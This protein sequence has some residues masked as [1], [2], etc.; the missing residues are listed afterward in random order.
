MNG[1]SDVRLS[2]RAGELSERGT[3]S[4]RGGAPEISRWG[5]FWLRLQTRRRLLELDEWQLRDIG[6]TRR[7]AHEEAFKPFWR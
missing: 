6:L 5:R 3:G 1:L 4:I 7:Q 2:L